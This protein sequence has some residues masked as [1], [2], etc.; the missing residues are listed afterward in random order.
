MVQISGALN[1]LKEYFIRAIRQALIFT[2][3]KRIG[4]HLYVLKSK[5]EKLNFL[6]AELISMKQSYDKWDMYEYERISV[7][8][9]LEIEKWSLM[10]DIK[11]SNS[12]F[13]SCQELFDFIIE[14]VENKLKHNINYEE[15][16]CFGPN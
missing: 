10:E 6:R 16:Y 14:L 11:E 8:I 13:Q 2:R 15:G 3:K 4:D 9:E 12:G 1:G 5:S 7:Y